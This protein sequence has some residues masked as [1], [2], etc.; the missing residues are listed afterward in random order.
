MTQKYIYNLFLVKKKI[1]LYSKYKI[2]YNL[3]I[4]H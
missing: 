4:I 1:F 2:P 3:I